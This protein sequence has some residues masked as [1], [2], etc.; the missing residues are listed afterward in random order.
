[1]L[2]LQRA[3]GVEFNSV[4]FRGDPLI[5]TALLGGAVPLGVQGLG[6]R[7]PALMAFTPERLPELPDVPTATGLGWPVVEQQFGGLIAPAGLPDEVVRRLESKCAVAI[8]DP[9][10]S[11]TLRTAGFAAVLRWR[12]M[13]RLSAG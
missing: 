13:R 1:M 8:R 10:I 3:A 12:P 5:V 7:V 2:A 6:S 11:D 9:R 4:P